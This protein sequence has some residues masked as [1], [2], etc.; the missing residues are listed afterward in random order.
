MAGRI[1]RSKIAELAAETIGSRHGR[2]VL[3]EHG[4]TEGMPVVIAQHDE[5]LSDV[6]AL[7]V[8]HRPPVLIAT[9][10]PQSNDLCFTYVVIGCTDLEVV[11][12]RNAN[13]SILDLYRDAQST[14]CLTFRVEP[15]THSAIAHAIPPLQKTAGAKYPG[16]PNVADVRHP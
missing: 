10:S 7:A 4:W 6:I 14:P 3:R 1:V 12:S 16:I 5:K 9:L 11:S 13:D 2:E 15:L 8:M